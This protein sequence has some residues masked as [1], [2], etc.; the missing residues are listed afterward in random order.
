MD[1]SPTS[2]DGDGFVGREVVADDM[3]VEFDRDRFVD[4]DQKPL[5]FDCSMPAV[6]CGNDGV[7]GDIECCE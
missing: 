7:V 3:H 5:E 6:Q 2:P 4:R 1:V